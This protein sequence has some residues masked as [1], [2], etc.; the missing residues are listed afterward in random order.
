[1]LNLIDQPGFDYGYP[2]PTTKFGL[3]CPLFDCFLM[4]GH[5]FN[6]LSDVQLLTSSK[7]ITMLI[8]L[9]LL[10]A[11]IN[12]IDNEVCASWTVTNSELINFTLIFKKINSIPTL[13]IQPKLVDFPEEVN[14]MQVWFIFVSHWVAQLNEQNNADRAVKFINFVMG[15]NLPDQKKQQ[16]YKILLLENDIDTANNQIKQL[17]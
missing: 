1:M 14:K 9:D 2:K 11:D 5:D 12:V 3:W 16:I 7:V 4:V 13:P 8:E 15:V 10:T 6:L 17:L